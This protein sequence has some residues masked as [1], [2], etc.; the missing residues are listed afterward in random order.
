MNRKNNS[1]HLKDA[2]NHHSHKNI[3]IAIIIVCLAILIGIV[4]GGRWL[5][6]DIL[7]EIAK[8]F[9]KQ[10]EQ[11]EKIASLEKQSKH[12]KTS[13]QTL[14]KVTVEQ[15]N[16]LSQQSRTSVIAQK[17]AADL[18]N[19]QNEQIEELSKQLNQFNTAG[20]SL[21]K[22]MTTSFN[23]H[24]DEIE[25]LGK[26]SSQHH[27][28]LLSLKEKTA[29]FVTQ[30]ALLK[31]AFGNQLAQLDKSLKGNIATLTQAQNNKV[32]SLTAQ[33]QSVTDGTAVSIK[34][35][36]EQIKE[37]NN[38][39]AQL[40]KNWQGEIATLEQA[41]NAKVASLTAQW[42]SLKDG[43]AVSI[44]KHNEQI[45]EL[46]NQSAQLEKTLKG[47]IATLAKTH[48]SSITLLRD[49]L[50]TLKGGTE[51]SIKRHTE[52]LE[53][54]GNQ[55]AQL[56]IKLNNDIAKLEQAQNSKLEKLTAKFHTLKGGTNTL[57]KQHTEQSEK[58]SKQSTRLETL[59]DD[60]DKLAQDQ[61]T[62]F[63]GFMPK[64]QT[65][66]G[67]LEAKTAT[68]IEQYNE[69][70]KALG[71]QSTQVEATLKGDIETSVQD[72]NSK[73]AKL[74]TQL[75]TLKEETAALIKQYNELE[76]QS[77]QSAQLEDNLKKEIATKFAS[78]TEQLQ[79]L[80][81]KTVI[82]DKQPINEELGNPSTQQENI[83][84]GE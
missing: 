10:N 74:T 65:L 7:S 41:Q 21:K 16:D 79:A 36:N 45:K 66:E 43:T 58:L 72:Q 50:H 31:K 22:E 83:L 68:F 57:I 29:N 77:H 39:S 38:Q 52:R 62:K 3:I 54:L 37:L 40:E 82:L 26:Q 32:A 76:K 28:D 34:K 60:I 14:K 59:K 64:I 13:L 17:R 2:E 6:Q 30:Q 20:R 55:S 5:Q 49:K 1:K 73:L 24:R 42:K 44:N 48:N 51:A 70:L 12:L 15:L 11:S 33:W 81:E 78:L 71:N 19:T 8:R 53:K 23:K 56:E 67:K 80:T 75:K 18:L 4:L 9:D 61:N 84:K 27:A 25:Q 63:T 47:E 35:H 46:D 69:Q